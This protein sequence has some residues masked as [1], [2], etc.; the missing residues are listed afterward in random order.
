M[1]LIFCMQLSKLQI[2]AMIL[3]EMVKYSQSSQNSKFAMS[4]QR[5]KKEVSDEV[6]FFLLVDFNNLDIKVF[7][8]MIL[9]DTH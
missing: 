9:D 2:D 5:L 1:Q 8:K 6:D 7:H 4:L 3:M